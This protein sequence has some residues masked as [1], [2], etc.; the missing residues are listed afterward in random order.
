MS[1]LKQAA[2]NI[3]DRR[4]KELDLWHNWNNNGRAQEHLEPLL[5]SIE[6]LIVREVDKRL[7]GT[8]GNISQVALKQNLR[9]SAVKSLKN[10]DPER[11]AQLSTHIVNGFRRSSDFIT[12]NRNIR[13]ISRPESEQYKRFSNVVMDLQSKLD[14]REPSPEEIRDELGWKGRVGL[15]R[16]TNLQKAFARELHTGTDGVDMSADNSLMPHT[17]FSV[18]RSGLTPEQQEFGDHYFVE[19]PKKIEAVAKTLGVSV[20]K[21][22]RIRAQIEKRLKPILR[23]Q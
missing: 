4:K 6:P 13:S 14:D 15:K 20:H 5:K 22:R 9:N 10:Y 18:V 12:A 23:N 8:A 21:A 19:N 11:G 1:K 3:R 16:V 2:D 7:V 17:A